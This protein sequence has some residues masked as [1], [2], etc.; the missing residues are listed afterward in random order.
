MSRFIRVLRLRRDLFARESL[1]AVGAVILA[2]AMLP[3]AARAQNAY[4]TSEA[5]GVSVIDIASSTVI[6]VIPTIGP[7][8]GVAVSPDNTHVYVTQPA[9]YVLVIDTASNAIETTIT[10]P[11]G[12]GVSSGGGIAVSPDGQH[13]YVASSNAIFVIR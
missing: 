13:V 7:A 11:G 1:C 8:I 6:A 12:A 9:F 4:I 5:S 10:L 2:I 3:T